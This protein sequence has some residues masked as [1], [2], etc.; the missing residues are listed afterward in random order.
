MLRT[1]LFTFLLLT[2]GLLLGS[3]S[4][5]WAGMPIDKTVTC[6]VG[7]EKFTIIGTASCTTM[8]RTMSFRPQTSCDFVTRLPVCPSNGLPI[9]DNFTQDQVTALTG[10]LKTS[11]Y[12]TIKKLP[13]WQ[14]AYALAAHLGQSGT[15]VAFWLLQNSMW[16]ETASFFESGVALDQL[17]HEAE[18]ELQRAPE[19]A[20]P[21]MNSVLAYALAYAGRIEESKERLRVAEQTPGK[22]EHLQNY[23]SAIEA[24]Q[25]DMSAPN[26]QPNVRFNW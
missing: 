14:R 5:A 13:P 17:L 11:D 6:P 22:S 19:D 15:E 3:G 18:F 12:E 16:Y 23:I 4:T 24:C 21:Y 7:G 8:G 26:C 10:F 25:T 20:K 2:S 9:F 1:V